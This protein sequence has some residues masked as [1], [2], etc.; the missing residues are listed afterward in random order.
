MNAPILE[1]LNIN[2]SFGGVHAVKDVSFK[3]E[4]GEL[5]APTARARRRSST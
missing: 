1:I 2:K 4:Q 5:A 3:I